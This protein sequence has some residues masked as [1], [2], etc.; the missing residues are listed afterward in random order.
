MTNKNANSPT[1]VVLEYIEE[2]VK[3]QKVQARG[4]IAFRTQVG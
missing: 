2:G 1:D 3:K 4:Q